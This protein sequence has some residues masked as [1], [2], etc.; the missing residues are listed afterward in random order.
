MF[1]T[2]SSKDRKIITMT[3]QITSTQEFNVISLNELCSECSTNLQQE[4]VIHG[5]CRPCQEEL[6]EEHYSDSS[7]L[8]EIE[9]AYMGTIQPWEN[10]PEIGVVADPNDDRVP[11]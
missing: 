3:N 10:S 7:E 9:C 5:V 2:R 1:I 6:I 4:D 11:F 8:T